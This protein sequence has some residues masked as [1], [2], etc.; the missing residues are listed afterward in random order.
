M[1]T[2]T[3]ITRRQRAGIVV[4]VVPALPGAAGDR[5]GLAAF[6]RSAGTAGD[7]TADAAD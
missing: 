7:E 5:E 6:G 2:K 4:R 3:E 1:M